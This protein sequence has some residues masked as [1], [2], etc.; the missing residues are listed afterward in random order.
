[1]GALKEP[2]AQK[3]TPFQGDGLVIAAMAIFGCSPLFFRFF[4]EIPTLAF[5]FALQVIG[6]L[7]LAVTGGIGRAARSDLLLISALAVV[8]IANDFFYFLAFRATTVANATITHQSVSIFLVF[9]TP[10]LLKQAIHKQEWVALGISLAGISILYVRG[11]SLDG[12]RDLLGITFGVLSG[13]F[14]ALAIIVY[15]VLLRHR[16]RVRT[17]NFWRY[18]ISTALL[19]PFVSV[20]GV[21]KIRPD[22]LFPLISFGVLFAAIAT[23]IHVLGISRTR[24]LHVSILGKTEPVFAILY[25][26]VVLGEVPTAE[27]VIGGG[28]ILG[29]SVW[30]ALRKHDDVDDSDTSALSRLHKPASRGGDNQL[31]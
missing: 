26:L 14:Y 3:T 15:T 18:G 9:L 23:G 27:A 13:F 24:P 31:A 28:L 29:S 19:L 4:P 22:D 10:L 2:S 1:M 20:L 25:A 12:N 8:A 7:A 5:L 6:A 11:A 17:V 21:S 16:V 30:L